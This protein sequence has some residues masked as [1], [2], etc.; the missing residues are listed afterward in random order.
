MRSTTSV[1]RTLLHPTVTY[2][3]YSCLVSS[4]TTTNSLKDNPQSRFFAVPF[5]LMSSS[6]PKLEQDSSPPTDSFSESSR[7]KLANSSGLRPFLRVIVSGS[8]CQIAHSDGSIRYTWNFL[9]CHL[10]ALVTIKDDGNISRRYNTDRLRVTTPHEDRCLA[11]TPKTKNGEHPTY[12]VS[13][14]QPQLGVENMQCVCVNIVTVGM[15]KCGMLSN[16]S[17]FSLQPDLRWS[18]IW[19]MPGTRHP[20]DNI[21]ELHGYGGARL[22]IWGKFYWAPE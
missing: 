22:L 2:W 9:K 19:K 15:W 21:I 12:L 5:K 8:A 14:L 13:C 20:Q 1:R 16:E 7:K 3:Y 6:E 18:F 4:N 10:W 17:R 11:L